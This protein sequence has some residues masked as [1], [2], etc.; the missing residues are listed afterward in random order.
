[1]V[2]FYVG[3]FSVIAWAPVDS[4]VRYLRDVTGIFNRHGWSWTYHAFREYP[5]WS[6]EH[7]DGV[8]RKDAALKPV[9]ESARGK[10][11]K[12]AFRAPVVNK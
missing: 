11:M 7:E 1:M 2:P 12:E 8:V 3:E 5:G 9:R 4:A 6:L 10:V